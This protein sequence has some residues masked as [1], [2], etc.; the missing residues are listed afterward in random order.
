MEKM[1]SIGDVS[2]LL[3]VRPDQVTALF[4]KGHLRDDLCPIIGGTRIIPEDYVDVIAMELK[5]RGIQPRRT[6]DGLPGDSK[7]SE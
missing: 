7:G 2:R 3:N 6:I 4:Y 5:R 1:L